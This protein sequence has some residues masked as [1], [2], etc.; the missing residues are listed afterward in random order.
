MSTPKILTLVGGISQGSLNKKLFN[1]VREEIGD[2][3]ELDLADISKLPFFS[4]DLEN[5]PPDQVVKFKDQIRHADAILFITPEY[6]HSIPGVLKNAIDWATRPYPENLWKH[7]PVA[8]MGASAGNTGT[9]GAQN[10]LRAVLI[11]L[12]AYILAQPEFY[13]NGSKVFDENGKLIDDKTRGRIQKFWSAFKE[14]IERNSTLG[15]DYVTPGRSQGLEDAP[16]L[17]H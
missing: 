8:T 10:H 1:A 17:Q 5:D 2:E 14:W 7:L 11:Y 9:Y 15:K 6:N 12:D 4:Q 16:Q 3:A 13:L